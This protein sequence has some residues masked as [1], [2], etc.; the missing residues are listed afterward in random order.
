MKPDKMKLEKRR[1]YNDDEIEADSLI[2]ES[3]K[4]WA[5]AVIYESR[6]AASQAERFGQ[7]PGFTGQERIKTDRQLSLTQQHGFTCQERRR[8]TDRQL[9]SVKPQFLPYL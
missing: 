2:P 3:A 8:E 5:S 7:Q 9:Q 4:Q 1:R 6:S